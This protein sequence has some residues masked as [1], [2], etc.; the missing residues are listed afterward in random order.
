MKH[1]KRTN[2][3]QERVTKTVTT[4]KNVGWSI[5]EI[6]GCQQ[7][8]TVAEV[9]FHHVLCKKLWYTEDVEVERPSRER[10]VFCIT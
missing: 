2:K 7:D 3:W 6:R 1:R 5:T 8:V 10:C 9:S 4:D